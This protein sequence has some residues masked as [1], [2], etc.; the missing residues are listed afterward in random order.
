[1]EV[2]ADEKL[3]EQQCHRGVT[4]AGFY[5]SAALFVCLLIKKGKSFGGEMA[6]ELGAVLSQR[7]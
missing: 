3:K 5:A 7:T 2:D 6:H 1:M 4:R